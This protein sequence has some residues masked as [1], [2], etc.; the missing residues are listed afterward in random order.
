MQPQVFPLLLLRD[1]PL[2]SVNLIKK[3]SCFLFGLLTEVI[4]FLDGETTTR[5]VWLLPH[6]LPT[7]HLLPVK[8]GKP[9]PWSHVSLESIMYW[10]DVTLLPLHRGYSK[11]F[12][13]VPGWFGHG[14]QQLLLFSLSHPPTLQCLRT[15]CE[16]PQNGHPSCWGLLA[17]RVTVLWSEEMPSNRSNCYLILWGFA[18]KQGMFTQL[19]LESFNNHHEI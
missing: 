2:W 13:V 8:G 14:E 12:C 17:Q 3:C 11:S 18:L 16:S 9:S 4:I 6:Y 19:G 7:L 1:N 10:T 5:C 15:T